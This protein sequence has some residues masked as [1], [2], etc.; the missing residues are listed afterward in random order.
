MPGLTFLCLDYPE[1]NQRLIDSTTANENSNLHKK[2]ERKAAAC[3]SLILT[4][5]PEPADQSPRHGPEVKP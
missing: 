5:D 3:E 4:A 2:E 1:Y